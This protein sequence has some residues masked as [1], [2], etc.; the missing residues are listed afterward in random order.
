MCTRLDPW[1]IKET[2]GVRNSKSNLPRILLRKIN[3]WWSGLLVWAGHWNRYSVNKSMTMIVEYTGVTLCTSFWCADASRSPQRLHTLFFDSSPFWQINIITWSKAAQVSTGPK[4][5][6]VYFSRS[7]NTRAGVRSFLTWS[8][9]FSFLAF[10]RNITEKHFLGSCFG[11]TEKMPGSLPTGF[12]SINS[13][14]LD[15]SVVHIFLLSNMTISSWFIGLG[16]SKWL[17]ILSPF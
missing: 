17:L 2:G 6:P 5:Y 1:S 14:H 12:R 13:I 4:S 10:N 7:I 15:P 3:F 8:V 9:G 16:V 11:F